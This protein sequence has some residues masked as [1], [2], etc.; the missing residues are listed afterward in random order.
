MRPLLLQHISRSLFPGL[1]A[2]SAWCLC[3]LTMGSA[4]PGG[5]AIL[6]CGIRGRFRI[7][8]I[9]QFGVLVRRRWHC[10]P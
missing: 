6:Q 10:N 4:Q 2:G 1:T 9:V 8:R 7:A 5:T 3:G